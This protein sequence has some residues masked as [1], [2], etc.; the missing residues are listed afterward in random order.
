M[1]YTS[2][3]RSRGRGIRPTEDTSTCSHRTA[4]HE[5]ITCAR[6]DQNRFIT[7]GRRYCNSKIQ[8]IWL[9]LTDKKGI[10]VADFQMTKNIINNE[11]GCIIDMNI[12]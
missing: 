9:E 11:G 4:R 2:G 6:V 12:F 7:P 1:F 10:D 8:N 3:G 5:S